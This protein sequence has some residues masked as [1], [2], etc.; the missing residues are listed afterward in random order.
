M[1]LFDQTLQTGGAEELAF[2]IRR[3]GQAI[4]MEHQNVSGLERDSPL[5]ISDFLKN[6]QGKSR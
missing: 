4:G 1:M 5:V 3:F 6:A 2:V